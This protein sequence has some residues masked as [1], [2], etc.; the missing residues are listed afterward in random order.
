VALRRAQR[1]SGGDYW[2]I[3]AGSEVG[4]D[5]AQDFDRTDLVLLEVSGID[6][7][8]EARMRSRLSQKT[9]QVRRVE[10][11]LRTLALVVGFRGAR[12]WVKDA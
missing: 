9:K 12:I 8:T 11:N 5:D 2:L 3:P 10:K 1:K 4:P 7:D 6:E